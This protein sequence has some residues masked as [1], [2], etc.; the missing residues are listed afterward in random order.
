MIKLDNKLI[1]NQQG[2]SSKENNIDNN[3]NPIKFIF[4]KIFS[5]FIIF[6]I[7]LNIIFLITHIISRDFLFYFIDEL[8]R[9]SFD[10]ESGH[11]PSYYFKQELI[12]YLGVKKSLFEEYGIYNFYDITLNDLKNCK[13]MIRLGKLEEVKKLSNYVKLKIKNKHFN[14]KTIELLNEVIEKS[15]IY[16]LKE[17]NEDAINWMEFCKK[18]K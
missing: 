1:I 17:L 5:Y 16:N 10:I 8:Y 9:P 15:Q 13:E 11:S 7:F 18:K 6:F 12:D 4:K 3:E 14:Q 2:N